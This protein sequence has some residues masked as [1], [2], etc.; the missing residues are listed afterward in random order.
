MKLKHYVT[1][2]DVDTLEV[3]HYTAEDD[4]NVSGRINLNNIIKNN[5]GY[6]DHYHD[7]VGINNTTNHGFEKEFRN[8]QIC[9][10]SIDGAKAY[11]II[12]ILIK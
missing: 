2:V 8:G 1:I 4:T 5:V 6:V 12:S 3:E 7:T 10:T 11:S 9:G